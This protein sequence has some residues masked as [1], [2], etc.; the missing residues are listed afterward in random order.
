MIFDGHHGGLS[1]DGR[2]YRLARRRFGPAGAQKPRLPLVSIIDTD[3][4]AWH[5]GGMA[6][7]QTMN[8][9]LPEAQEQ[10][11]RAQVSTGRYRTASEVVRDGLRMLEK[12][13]HRRLLEKWI[14]EDLSDEELALL[15]EELKQRTR[16]YFQGL[17]D[18]GLRSAEEHGWVD[19]PKAMERIRAELLGNQRDT[20]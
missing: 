9:S 13:E 20:S 6:Q 14:Y 16:A 15:P 10:F 17:I 18:E 2:G 19:G 3:G 5:F 1:R 11:V 4:E 8:V 7:R 12:A